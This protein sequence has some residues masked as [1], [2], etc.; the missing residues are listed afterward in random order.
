[1]TERREA[2]LSGAAAVLLGQVLLLVLTPLSRASSD[3]VVTD[4]IALLAPDSFTYLELAE[5]PDWLSTPWNRLLLIVLLRMGSVLGE[6]ATLLVVLQVVMLTV[7]AAL[8][9]RLAAKVGGRVAGLLAAAVVA[10]NPLTA[11]WVRFVL[12]ETLFLALVLIVLWAGVRIREAPERNGLTVVLVSAALLATFLRPN[13]VLVLGSALTLLVLARRP[14]FRRTA[15]LLSWVAVVVGLGLGLLAAGQPAERSLTEQ[16]YA[17]VVIEGT[18][19]VVVT[20]DMPAPED[21]TDTREVAGLQYAVTHPLAVGR[22]IGA[23]MLVEVAQVRRHY[24]PVVNVGIGAAMLGFL[25]A[26]ALSGRMP[27]AARSRSS[28]LIIGAPILLLVGATFATPEGRYG[29]GALIVLAPLAGIGA[30]GGLTTLLVGLR[31]PRTGTGG[32]APSR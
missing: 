18:E 8:A 5:A 3:G 31:R 9:H 14:R 32:N 12:T 4:G 6:P 13:G 17:G 7:A 11:Q 2:F 24:P 25:G 21:P 16:L 10:V 19:H 22:L 1:M 20:L 30:G 27:A 29:W 23:R 28:A 26:A 15:I